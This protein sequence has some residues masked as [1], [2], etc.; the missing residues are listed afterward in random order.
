MIIT[1]DDF[2]HEEI[3]LDEI[4]VKSDF[5]DYKISVILSSEKIDHSVG[6][7]EQSDAFDEFNK[8]MSV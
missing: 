3:L 1:F 8:R 6:L 7:N 4:D 2:T 5:D